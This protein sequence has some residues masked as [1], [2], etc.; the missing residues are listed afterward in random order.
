[1]TLSWRKII[2]A[3]F[4]T[5]S[6]FL[7]RTNLCSADQNLRS[8][9]R[10][11]DSVIADGNEHYHDS[12]PD[13]RV[14]TE[15]ERPVMHTFYNRIDPN[16][17]HK[18]GGMTDESDAQLLLVWEAAWKAAGWKTR[19][20][21]LEDAKKHPDYEKFDKLLDL[22]KMPFG[23]YDKLC[24]MRWLAMAAVG[25]GFMS[26][27][28]TFPLRY[29][30]KMKDLPRGGKLTVYDTVR[31][32]GVPS[33]VSGSGKEFDRMAHALLYNT[34]QK[35]VREEFWS[36]MFALMDVYTTDNDVYLLFDQV[37][38]GNAALA[39]VKNGLSSLRECKAVVGGNFAV[40]FSHFSITD[41]V[42]KGH[43]P[44]GQG[45]ADR[46]KIAD[47]FLKN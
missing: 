29:F 27:Y 32:G 42:A 16:V 33:V 15:D 46:P 11:L 44:K 41:S 34:L 21:T 5:A 12:H 1:M 25:G 31:S 8:S 22:E 40:H 38:K 26:D 37:V 45:A 43:L 3:S 7:L 17:H 6:L 10:Q 4:T 24:F 19:I 35:G 47:Q 2:F 39:G 14:L 9:S 36:D 13:A 18:Y 28:D 23:F 20:V 30:A